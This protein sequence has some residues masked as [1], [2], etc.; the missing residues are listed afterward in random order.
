MLLV[1]ELHTYVVD[2]VHHLSG[3]LVN[4]IADPPK[5]GEVTLPGDASAKLSKLLGWGK[6][7]VY[8]A[9]TGGF[10]A[11]AGKMALSYHRGEEAPWGRLATIA[12]ACIIGGGVVGI[13]D[14]LF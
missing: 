13:V 3:A 6:A 11:A 4:P 9:C 1:L 10:L 8:V 5:P 14:A 2:A 12:G 7:L